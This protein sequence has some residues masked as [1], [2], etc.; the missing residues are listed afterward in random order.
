M[1]KIKNVYVKPGIYDG[2]RIL[3]ER[4]WPR[5]I[6]RSSQH[7][8]IWLKKLGPSPEL[9]KWFLHNEDSWSE[10]N[11]KYKKEITN[12]KAIEKLI[13]IV[14]STDVVTLLF[15]KDNHEENDAAVVWKEV[16]RVLI[17]MDKYV[18]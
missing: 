18:Q 9:H 3:V 5:G 2:I 13:D 16:Q 12:S 10:Y 7:V 4:R 6:R 1:I 11:K 14:L 15:T 8:D 17:K